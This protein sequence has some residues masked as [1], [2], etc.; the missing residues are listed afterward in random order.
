MPLMGNPPALCYIS[1]IS[2]EHPPNYT[3]LGKALC[4]ACR[5]WHRRGDKGQ[6]QPLRAEGQPLHSHLGKTIFPGSAVG[7]AV[8]APH[9]SH[10]FLN[11][12]PPPNGWTTTPPIHEQRIPAQ[13]VNRCLHPEVHSAFMAPA[14][15]FRF[16]HTGTAVSLLLMLGRLWGLSSVQQALGLDIEV[17]PYQLC[18]AGTSCDLGNLEYR[19][20]PCLNPT[21]PN[22]TQPNPTHPH[23][24]SGTL[25]LRSPTTMFLWVIFDTPTSGS[26]TPPPPPPSSTGLL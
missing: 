5:L 1:H 4:G 24:P 25:P 6:K 12:L 11:L 9:L 3:A 13:K 22:P 26:Q 14:P 18:L 2:G 21:Q 15:P 10:F 7:L 16:T 23:H 19:W 17:S 8:Q 20:R